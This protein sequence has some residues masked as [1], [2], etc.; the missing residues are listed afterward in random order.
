MVGARPS[1]P[2]SFD[3]CLATLFGAWQPVAD[4]RIGTRLDDAFVESL[5]FNPWHTGGGLRPVGPLMRLRK[6]AYAGS[7]RGRSVDPGRVGPWP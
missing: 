2:E 1:G 4:L 6:P 5:A 7:Q 3:L